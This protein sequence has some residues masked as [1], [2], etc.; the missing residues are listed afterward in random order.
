MRPVQPVKNPM[1][2]VQ[3]RPVRFLAVVLCVLAAARAAA[4]GD[5]E[6]REHLDHE[7]TNELLFFPLPRHCA[8]AASVVLT[9]RDGRTTNGQV[10]DDGR[11]AFLVDLPA[12]SRASWTVAP[13]STDSAED[14]QWDVTPTRIRVW[15]NLVGFEVPTATGAF[16]EGPLAA[17][18]LRS[19]AWAG[20]S[21]LAT[22]QT[23]RAYSA[24]ITAS[25][26]VYS[27][28]ECS[29]TFESGAAWR[30]R[31]R[32]ISGEPVIEIDESFDLADG[33]V[34]EFVLSEN[35]N[36][37]AF[38]FR[39]TMLKHP[40]RKHN[41]TT[42]IMRDRTQPA[43]PLI[44]HAWL[45]W[46]RADAVTFFGAFEADDGIDYVYDFDGDGPVKA[47]PLQVGIEGAGQ[48]ERPMDLETMDL[49]LTT[50]QHRGDDRDVFFAAAG[51]ASRWAEAGKR[52]GPGKGVPIR[53]QPDGEVVL[54][55]QLEGPGRSWIFG[56]ST[57]ENTV[58]PNPEMAEPQAYYLKYC[59]TPLAEV[60]DMVL[61]WETDRDHAEWPRIFLRNDEIAPI[62]ELYPDNLDWGSGRKKLYWQFLTAPTPELR[63]HMRE[64]A[65][66]SLAHAVQ[67]FTQGHSWRGHIGPSPTKGTVHYCDR[68][69]YLMF[70]LDIAF[71]QE[72]FTP[73]ETARIRA[74]LAFLA[75]RIASP[76][77][78]DLGRDY[79]ANPNM[80]TLRHTAVGMLG[81]MLRRHPLSQQWYDI[82]WLEIDRQLDEFS[83]PNGGWIE[84]PHYQ[85]L[86][87]SMILF[88]AAA[89]REGISEDIY[90]P[91][92]LRSIMFLAKIHT[93]RDHSFHML[94]H[95]PAVGDTPRYA[96]TMI[97]SMMAKIH[98]DRTPDAANALQWVWKESGS[99]HVM[100]I[101]GDAITNHFPEFLVAH[102]EPTGPPDW[103]SEH[104]PV[105]GAVLR[106]G[107]PSDRETHMH[108]YAGLIWS[109]Y[110]TD[111]G[112][113]ILYGKGQPLVMDW[114][115]KGVMPAWW[116]SKMER[117]NL[118]YIQEFETFPAMDYLRYQ[119]R[120][121][122]RQ[123]LFV[124][125]SD[126]M[127]PNYFV[128]RDVV[129][130]SGSEGWN[131]WLY[132][133]KVPK[134]SD[135][136]VQALGRGDADLDVWLPTR[137]LD[138]LPR[139]SVEDAEFINHPERRSS[140]LAG[141]L[142][143]NTADDDDLFDLILEGEAPERSPYVDPRMHS[144]AN[145]TGRVRPGT[146]PIYKRYGSGG[147][148]ISQR[149][150]HLDVPHGTPLIWALY[151]RMRDDKGA[152]FTPIAEDRGA[153]I[154]TPAG[155]DYVFLSLDAFEYADGPL[156]FR[157]TAGS[158]Q[159]N[160]DQIILT[161]AAAG[162]IR[163]GEHRLESDTAASK[164]FPR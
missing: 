152:V 67:N 127:A 162:S 112:S 96:L 147:E 56:T 26:P 124:K 9:D 97:T 35:F 20:K 154:E 18:R 116:H 88:L 158:V 160:P 1:C 55:A 142:E 76:D 82:G 110:S 23:I 24:E 5:I 83:G 75:Y 140:S 33:S 10:T 77:Y 141:P 30:L 117:G 72:L 69:K 95:M 149:G 4:A 61:E 150:L 38:T 109:H 79:R 155:I 70:E 148:G 153:T 130:G 28:V 42:V 49:P 36:P 103:T 94:R 151:P 156:A 68:L 45:P 14:L 50:Q 19:G 105:G 164:S 51:R 99:P 63:Q 2:S 108:F 92:L 7:W 60:N 126:P 52:D 122:Q 135:G 32:I 163:F 27:E 34:W 47:T 159:I 21:R 46:W 113:F 65:L 120:E 118:G 54:R 114:G 111:N 78:Y 104:F 62:A 6:I 13:G 144:Y 119:S 84:C 11:V 39:N 22:A 91:R 106:S 12:G 132:S 74:Q 43:T 121:W 139:M 66:G 59:V 16:A 15:N 131:L 86:M 80:T 138:Q 25:G 136:V 3:T 57:V 157:G 64:Q 161:L 137:W 37:T 31:F 81:C 102:F 41:A 89:Q 29:Y 134:I 40:G 44:L 71:G 87:H 90:D 100:S 133:D 107:F 93:P 53:T 125:R 115:Y 85:T 17:V 58:R 98:R 101:G 146:K 48:L 129:D 128:L 143:Q 123:V 145:A 73:K 8:G